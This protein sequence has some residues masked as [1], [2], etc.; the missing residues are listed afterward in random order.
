MPIDT[1][2]IV[3]VHIGT[4]RQDVYARVRTNKH[5]ERL[6][7]R[8]TVDNRYSAPM[9]SRSCTEDPSDEGTLLVKTKTW[10]K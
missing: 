5:D 4:V 3:T 9:S 6:M 2:A 8:G 1:A 7:P 10:K